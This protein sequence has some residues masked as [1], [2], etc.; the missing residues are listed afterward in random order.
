MLPL[1]LFWLFTTGDLLLTRLAIGNFGAIEANPVMAVAIG[2][3][4]SMA[5]LVKVTAGLLVTGVCVTFWHSAAIRRVLY[6]GTIAFVLVIT[7]QIM[8]MG[9]W[10]AP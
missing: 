2:Q 7:Y 10:L 4:W 3:S 5:I 1:S 8:A 9:T 6:L